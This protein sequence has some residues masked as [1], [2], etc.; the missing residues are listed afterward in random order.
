MGGAL[1]LPKKLT[2]FILVV[3]LKDRL[4]IP[5]NLEAT[6]QKLNYP[7]NDSCSGWGV[8]FVSCGALTHFS[9]K[10]GLTKNFTAGGAGAPAGYAY[11]Y[12]HQK[13]KG[14]I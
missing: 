7:K 9:C 11:V 5:P 1:F 10:L 12:I 3:A 4:N 14:A 2:T 8:H 13:C 6:K